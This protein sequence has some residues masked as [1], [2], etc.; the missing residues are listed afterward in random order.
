MVN[1]FGNHKVGNNT[2]RI[3]P[4]FAKQFDKDIGKLMNELK[5]HNVC[6]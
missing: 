3:K 4:F 6:T 1:V 2:A 5:V